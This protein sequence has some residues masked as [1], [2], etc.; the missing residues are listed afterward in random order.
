MVN[1]HTQYN[2]SDSGTLL[3]EVYPN[4]PGLDIV[5]PA[6]QLAELSVAKESDYKVKTEYDPETKSRYEVGIANRSATESALVFNPAWSVGV[7]SPMTRREIDYLAYLHPDSLVVAVN[8]GA[9]NG[10]NL[11][12][13]LTKDAAKTGSFISIGAVSGRLAARALDLSGHDD[14]E[15]ITGIGTSMGTRLILG[16]AAILAYREQVHLEPVGVYEQPFATLSKAFAVAEGEHVKAYSRES[17]DKRMAELQLD[18][19]APLTVMRSLGRLVLQSRLRSQLID[20]PK[21]MAR[22]EYLNDLMVV[23]NNIGR[24]AIVLAELSEVHDANKSY[25]LISASGVLPEESKVY[26]VPRAT[27]SLF[28]GGNAYV[29]ASVGKAV[30]NGAN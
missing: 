4:S 3:R 5:I 13:S 16:S 10:E 15:R 24:L 12:R 20:M 23:R 22:G 18:D 21:A 17:I 7:D 19:I 14:H 26:V 25:G 8:P 2:L 29:S 11:P 30:E 9:G 27:H 1:K 6:T 28:S